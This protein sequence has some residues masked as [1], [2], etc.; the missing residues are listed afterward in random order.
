VFGLVNGFIEH[1]YTRLGTTCDYNAIADF[2]SE[3]QGTHDHIL[4]SQIRNF[5]QPGGPGARIYIPQEQGGPVIPPG[6]GFPLFTSYVSQDYGG[7]IRNR[8]R[9]AWGPR[10]VASGLTQ[11][12]SPPR[13]AWFE[14]SPEGNGEV[15]SGSVENERQAH[16]GMCP[17]SPIPQTARQ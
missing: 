16:A 11:K 17:A 9:P 14:S 7:G 12:K 1:S 2:R 15:E 10:Y 4:L 6:T 8:L 5:P 3:S 13:V